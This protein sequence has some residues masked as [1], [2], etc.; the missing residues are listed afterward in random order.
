MPALFHTP[1]YLKYG[2]SQGIDYFGNDANNNY[3]SLQITADKRLA[4]GLLFNASYTFQH[5]NYYSNNGYYN[6]DPKSAY[7]PNANYRNHVFILTQVYYLP[8]G[9]GKRFMSDAG[10]LENLVVG[11]WSVNSAWNIS[12]G[13]PWQPSLSSCGASIDSG[14]CRPNIIG[15]VQD[16]TRSGHPDTT[17]Y[18]FRTSPTPLNSLCASGGAW[19]Q[20]CV[21]G[22]LGNAG[23]N[24]MRGPKFFNA[25][26][27]LFKDFSVTE[28]Y[29]VQFQFQ[30]FNLFNH[31]NLDLPNT[32]VDCSNGGSITNIAFGA[33]MRRLQFG[34]KFAF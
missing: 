10:T 29:R 31:A 32:C 1:F 25:D 19:Q 8:F 27:A 7:G 30:M 9:K 3:E 24:S 21:F 11:G 20:A 14:P 34:L 26:A 13:L 12:S 6:I 22:A 15:P 17:A 28:R 4:N 18:W 2:W 33:Q 23:T 5:A 16:G